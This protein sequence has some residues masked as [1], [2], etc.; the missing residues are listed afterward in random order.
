MTSKEI[1]DRVGEVIKRKNLITEE[2]S[3][4]LGYKYDTLNKCVKR[5]SSGIYLAMD[6]IDG[7]GLE[8]QLDNIAVNSHQEFIDYVN[9]RNPVSL[10]I[11]KSTGISRGTIQRLKEGNNVS[12]DKAVRILEAMGIEVRVV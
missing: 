1:F 4:D 5:G 12:F 7:V 11:S 3:V 2:I 9:A 6:I 8:L 10:R